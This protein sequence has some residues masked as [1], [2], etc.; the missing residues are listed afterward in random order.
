ML[1]GASIAASRAQG[2]TRL[3]NGTPG[4]N[5][6]VRLSDAG[7]RAER[8]PHP[9]ASEQALLAGR[10]MAS[11]TSLRVGLHSRSLVL[12]RRTIP[13]RDG[14]L[15]WAE[16]HRG[17]VLLPAP[18][19]RL[20]ARPGSAGQP[21][22]GGNWTRFSYNP[23]LQASVR[24]ARRYRG[25]GLRHN[26][27][28]KRDSNPAFLLPARP[29]PRRPRGVLRSDRRDRPGGSA[30]ACRPVIPR[31]VDTPV[32]TSPGRRQDRLR[33]RMLAAR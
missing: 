28:H 33:V 26:S 7:T 12:R 2:R 14:A 20:H 32:R 15:T 23:D 19:L 17:R 31:G 8:C 4:A 9:P 18:P 16:T 25:M 21:A 29:S 3:S 10:K 5:C 13:G 11:K 24:R 27:T 1:C 22:P 30:T 6:G